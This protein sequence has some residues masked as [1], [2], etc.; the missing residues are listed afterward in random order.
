MKKRQL[1]LFAFLCFGRVLAQEISVSVNDQ[2]AV[3]KLDQSDYE[4]WATNCNFNPRKYTPMIYEKFKDDFDFVSYILNE[5]DLNRK[6]GYSGI[7]YQIANY[8]E[9]TGYSVYSNSSLYGSDG[10]LI[11]ILHMPCWDAVTDGPFLHEILHHWANYAIATIDLKGNDYTAHWGVTGGNTKGQLGGFQQST[12]KRDG[13]SYTVESFGVN[14]NGGNSVPYNQ[15]ELYLMGMIPVEEVEPFSVFRDVSDVENN[16]YNCSFTSTQEEIYTPQRLVDELGERKPNY[17]ESQKDFRVLFVVVT[18]D[19]LTEE[20]VI[21][22]NNMI[23]EF[24][25]NKKP[26]KNHNFYSATGGRGTFTPGNISKSLRKPNVGLSVTFPTVSSTPCDLY[27]PLNIEWTAEISGKVSIDLY[28]NGVKLKNIAQHVDA[29]VQ[30]YSWLP[31]L[32][33]DKNFMS[34]FV[35]LTSEDDNDIYSFST[36]F[37]FY[38]PDYT[39]SGKVLDKEG[40]GIANAIVTAGGSAPRMIIELTE[41]DGVGD[42]LTTNDI[43]FIPTTEYI[44]SFSFRS[45]SRGNPNPRVNLSILDDQGVVIWKD[46]A[47]INVS[48]PWTEIKF[49]KM[50]KV[51]PNAKYIFR[52]NKPGADYSDTDVFYLVSLADDFLNYVHKVMGTDAPMT[53]TDADGN[54]SLTLPARWSSELTAISGS[55]V[56]DALN[57]TIDNKNLENQY[58][59][60]QGGHNP[61]LSAELAD[62]SLATIWASQKTVVVENYS[63]NLRVVDAFGR[64]VKSVNVD[65]PYTEIEIPDVGVYLVIAGSKMVKVIVR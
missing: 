34:Y 17:K 28:K 65:N 7:S 29:S 19:D 43:K 31:S 40:V 21:H 51:T 12:L 60:E 8:E 20:E 18:N 32:P 46:E 23:N 22:Y 58:I 16:Y 36:E 30:E 24:C 9:G 61:S 10:K 62:N 37:D 2:Y 14:A 63:G 6:F 42:F 15:L 45:F 27:S 25:S 26:E 4:D 41:T 56:F 54:Y 55:K 39:V 48:Q 38:V 33:E 35:K 50:I 49:S 44:T 1:L 47:D 52:I 13:N 57:I 3:M 53:Y 5:R 59:V 64:I 11:Q